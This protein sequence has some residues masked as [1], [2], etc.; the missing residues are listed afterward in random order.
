MG[1]TPTINR[2][3]RLRIM[4]SM[5]GFKTGDNVCEKGTRE[6]GVVTDVSKR[7]GKTRVYISF[8][9][10]RTGM[11]DENGRP[12]TAH[13]PNNY[14]IDPHNPPIVPLTTEIEQQWADEDVIKKCEQLCDGTDITAEQARK[15]IAILKGED[16]EYGEIPDT[17]KKASASTFIHVN[18]VHDDGVHS[19]DRIYEIPADEIEAAKEAIYSGYETWS[20]DEDD[21]E[22]FCVWDRI[23]SEFKKYGIYYKSIGFETVRLT[24]YWG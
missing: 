12:R 14:F 13:L 17:V 11:Y 21:Y 16:V 23:E 6:T 8:D 24:N 3:E 4:C 22:E 2:K 19:S 7:N 10:G 9:T 5:N 18:M 20:A 15:I 1:L